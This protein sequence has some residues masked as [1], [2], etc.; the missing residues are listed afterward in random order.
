MA[1]DRSRERRSHILPI[2]VS[3]VLRV[4]R[5][6]AVISRAPPG[7]QI[8]HLCLN[9]TG[10]HDSRPPT[11]R[12]S[13]SLRECD[14]SNNHPPRPRGESAQA[15]AFRAPRA[16]PAPAGTCPPAGPLGVPRQGPSESINTAGTEGIVW[17]CRP[18]AGAGGVR[19]L[20][21]VTRQLVPHRAPSLSGVTRQLAPHRRWRPIISGPSSA[22]CGQG[23]KPLLPRLVSPLRDAPRQQ[24]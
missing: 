23:L 6:P 22:S 3:R 10:Q 12:R 1:L 7:V 21:G 24:T 11:T 16:A 18:I 20:S 19:A 13:E 2:R 15:R 17:G 4:I 5:P 9:L 14:G 8:L